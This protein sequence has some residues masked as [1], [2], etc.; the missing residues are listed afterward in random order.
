MQPL[1]QLPII[2]LGY[3]SKKRNKQKAN[4]TPGL[5]F[6]FNAIVITIQISNASPTHLN[7]AT[8]SMHQYQRPDACVQISL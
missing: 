8:Q 3:F 7:R 6:C 4:P 5:A 1:Q 2:W